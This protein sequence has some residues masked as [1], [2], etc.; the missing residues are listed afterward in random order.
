MYL[1]EKIRNARLC[2]CSGQEG[3]AR[4]VFAGEN[5]ECKVVLLQG[6]GRKCKACICRREKGMQGCVLARDKKEMQG[7]YLQEKIRNARLCSCSGQERN[8]RHISHTYTH[9]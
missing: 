1:Q 2:I 4:R 9:I 7:M 8:A 5:K 3:N 6:T